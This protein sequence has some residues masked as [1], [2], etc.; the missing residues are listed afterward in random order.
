VRALVL[1]VLVGCFAAGCVPDLNTKASHVQQTRV[2]AVRATPAE[3]TPGQMVTWQAV[4]VTPLMPQG[5]T[6]IDWS[7]CEAP[8]NPADSITVTGACFGDADQSAA[9]GGAPIVR[10]I[11]VGHGATVQGA[12]PSD[13]CRKIGPEVSAMGAPGASAQRPP[14]ADITGG[15]QL[16]LRLVL[17]DPTGAD[18]RIDISFDRQRVRCNLANAPAEA[19]RAYGMRYKANQNPDLSGIQLAGMVLGPNDGMTY[20][21][22]KGSKLPVAIGWDPAARET[23][24]LFDPVQREVVERTETL[25]VSWYT[26]GGEF[27]HDRTTQ[28]GANPISSNTLSLDPSVTQPVKVWI[29]LRD[30]RGGVGVGTLNLAPI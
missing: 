28:D 11:G 5:Q 30:E 22:P 2:V 25:D 20:Q 1:P 26:N 9:D 3:A 19:A 29:I 12:I 10:S 24:V 4:V 13:A 17:G 18:P 6:Q 15:Y 8:R 14:D 16:P 7:M 21:V 27:E 23:Y